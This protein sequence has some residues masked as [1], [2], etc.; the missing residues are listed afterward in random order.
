MLRVVVNDVSA[1]PELQFTKITAKDLVNQLRNVPLFALD[2]KTTGPDAASDKIK[3]ITL[4][5]PKND[6]YILTTEVI[7]YELLRVL[8]DDKSVTVHS[9]LKDISFL[10]F[11]GCKIRSCF[12]TCL[13]DRVVTRSTEGELSDY[14]LRSVLERYGV[15]NSIDAYERGLFWKEGFTV[16]G[17]NYLSLFVRYLFPLKFKI[18]QE[19]KK[20]VSLFR[21]MNKT[22]LMSAYMNTSP[23]LI[24]EK[25][26]EKEAERCVTE[27]RSEED[28]LYDIFRMVNDHPGKL[29][30]EPL[31]TDISENI[32]PIY[33]IEDEDEINKFLDRMYNEDIPFDADDDIASYQYGVSLMKSYA[34]HVRHYNNVIRRYLTESNLDGLLYQHCVPA[35]GM[36]LQMKCVD[37]FPRATYAR[38]NKTNPILV[39]SI[40][41]F[42]GLLKYSFI[43]ASCADYAYKIVEVFNVESFG[44]GYLSGDANVLR[45][46]TNKEEEIRRFKVDLEDAGIDSDLKDK[47]LFRFL[48]NAIDSCFLITNNLLIKCGIDPQDNEAVVKVISK[49][50]SVATSI[51]AEMTNSLSTTGSFTVFGTYPIVWKNFAK[52]QEIKKIFVKDFWASYPAHLAKKDEVYQQVQFYYNEV[53][54]A[55][56][57][58]R[59]AIIDYSVS[60]VM[61]NIMYMIF[62]GI[63]NAGMEEIV[64][65][66]AK[67][68]TSFIIEYPIANEGF[69]NTLMSE[70]TKLI[71]EYFGG[72]NVPMTITDI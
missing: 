7:K 43:G 12:D 18:I 39:S 67:D 11:N 26:L 9:G 66:K 25:E 70:S 30:N 17:C 59:D 34:E 41:N 48:Q 20:S 63:I 21:L 24:D 33:D 52:V 46:A 65:I 31:F 51:I 10:I 47:H 40:D 4:A 56:K 72:R 49:R 53:R 64:T 42:D 2:L 29:N 58:L 36:T 57:T 27:I 28:D 6:I 14:S 13:C 37:N 35:S 54:K 60:F 44:L 23:I 69:V 50:Y 45:F 3:A 71:S 61:N 62:D 8:F 38:K 5:T 32:M 16:A 1:Y 68:R 19:H 55:D 22:L 15:D